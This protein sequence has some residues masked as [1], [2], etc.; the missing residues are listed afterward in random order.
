VNLVGKQYVFFNEQLTKEEYE[1]RLQS[2]ELHRRSKVEEMRQRLSAHRLTFPH[3]FMLGEMNEDVTGSSILR[4]RRM[5]DCFDVSDD[6]DCRYC[7]W[8]HQAKNCMDCYSWGHTAEESLNCLEVGAGS[9]HVLFSLMTYNGTNIYYCWNARNGCKDCFGCVSPRRSQ[10]CVL[11][12]Q[13]TQG[14]YEDLVG[15]IIAH[16]QQ[17]GEWGRFFPMSICP[18]NYNQTI[19]QDYFPLSKEQALA[20][21]A[22]WKDEPPALPPTH[23][24][25]IPDS[26]RDADASICNIVH[27]CSETS[28]PFKIIPQEFA[29]YQDRGIPVPTKSFFARHQ[30]RLQRRN[31]RRLWDRACM[32]CGKAIR[33]SYAPERPE[34]V[35]CEQCYL[36]TVY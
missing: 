8:F 11:N 19:A 26:I 20:L 31:P 10:Y 2:A 14:E 7:T 15:T 28:K 21:G 30:A 6:E 5:Y 27:T 33:T 3:R 12:K 22:S 35:Y 4:S 36:E 1:R 16:M 9:Y 25:S 18:L 32:Q 23:P 34:I 29:F 24:E 17:T 13:Y